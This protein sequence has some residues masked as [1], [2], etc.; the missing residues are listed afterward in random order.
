[1]LID[2]R[3]IALELKETLR[4]E[5]A[6]LDR[7][8]G[9]AT[10]LVGDDL[11][12]AGL[13]APDRPRRAA[14]SAIVSRPENMPADATLGQVIGKIAELDARPRDQRDPR[15]APAAAAPAGVARVP[16]AAAC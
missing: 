12:R 13:P 14:R 5:L 9:I 3:A 15:A 8:A 6:A 10:L 4:E 11:A 1:M 16:R 7:P 2:G